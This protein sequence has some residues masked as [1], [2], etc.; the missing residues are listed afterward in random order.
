MTV[1]GYIVS[2]MVS[3][4]VGAYVVEHKM[5]KKSHPVLKGTLAA[6]A[7][8][9]IF[10]TVAMAVFAANSENLTTGVSGPPPMLRE[11]RFI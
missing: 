9:V 2:G 4:Y 10:A 8:N 7:V 5:F 11:P 3:G 1:G 6:G